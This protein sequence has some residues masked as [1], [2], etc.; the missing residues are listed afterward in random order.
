MYKWSVACAADMGRR[1]E[2][3]T[4]SSFMGMHCSS[5]LFDFN[6]PREAPIPGA[7][8]PL[9]MK[10]AAPPKLEEEESYEDAQ[11]EQQF[12]VQDAAWQEGDKAEDGQWEEEEDPNQD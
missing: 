7:R 11:C 5:R 8:M 4:F 1:H 12:G 6:C 10:R 9:A 2:R 3:M